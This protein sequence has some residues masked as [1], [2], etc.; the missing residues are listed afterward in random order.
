[1]T[2][3]ITCA[4]LR[5][6]SAHSP[7]ETVTASG[8]AGSGYPKLVPQAQALAQRM[9]AERAAG[10]PSA[11]ICGP[12]LQPDRSWTAPLRQSTAPRSVCLTAPTRSP[13]RRLIAAA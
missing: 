7:G 3:R 6:R 1:M 13:A 4:A 5:S 11:L 9:A 12:A 8:F 10:V 2:D